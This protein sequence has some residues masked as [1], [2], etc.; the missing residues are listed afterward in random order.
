MHSLNRFCVRLALAFAMFLVSTASVA[1][2]SQRIIGGRPVLVDSMPSI[3]AL[4]NAQTLQ[5]A[6]SVSLSQFCGGTLIAPSWVLTAAHCV[7]VFDQVMTPDNIQVVANS[8]DLDNI[9]GDLADVVRVITHE[10]YNSE[11]NENDIALLQ[12][13]RSVV[14][15]SAVAQL[16]TKPVPLNERVVV[17][18]WGA[19]QFNFDDGS[20]D[21]PNLLHSVEVLALPATQCNTLP[22]YAD[23]ITSTM[24]CAGFEAGERDSCQGDSGGP[25]YRQ[26]DDGNII[27]AGVTSW[28]DGC[29]LALRP[30]VYTDVASFNRWIESNMGSLL[31]APVVPLTE[32]LPMLISSSGS[33][34]SAG[35]WLFGL[36]A[37]FVGWRRR[38][39]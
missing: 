33:G 38:Q 20:F 2:T 9:V 14:S 37:C 28:G 5:N 11:T 27:V 17:A 16:N 13:N 24:L 34:G 19:R 3:V 10:N 1:N 39:V 21:F 36:I 31:D 29:A 6:G 35:V 12:L 4:I 18:G 8:H 23:R 26:S 32:P 7:V 22:A 15:S 25:L 30:G